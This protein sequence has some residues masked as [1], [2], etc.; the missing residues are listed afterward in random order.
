MKTAGGHMYWQ[1]LSKLALCWPYR[2]GT[3]GAARA[4]EGR[5]V[6]AAAVALV[7]GA[8]ELDVAVVAPVG[9]PRVAD[10]PVASAVALHAVAHRHDVVV[11]VGVCLVAA[12]EDA[13]LV[14]LPVDGLLGCAGGG[15]QVSSK[16]LDKPL[17][18]LTCAPPS[19]SFGPSPAHLDGDGDGAAVG[20]GVQERLVLVGGVLGVAG[21]VDD[22]LRLVKGALKVLAL[23]RHVG[24]GPLGLEAAVLLHLRARK[25]KRENQ[26]F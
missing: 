7:G 3:A 13:R 25:R 2:G 6:L 12:V 24:V 21:H 17:L 5:Y 26:N 15:Q 22:G 23:P 14:V 1:N 16:A 20:N 11:N 19:I 10:E 9:G 8:K 4:V 18:S